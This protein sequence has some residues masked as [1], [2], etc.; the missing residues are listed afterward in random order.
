MATAKK[1]PVG[2]PQRSVRFDPKVLAALTKAAKED[3]RPLSALIQKIVEEWLLE[4]GF[5][6]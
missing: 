5:L 6:K 2:R 3:K 1:T 4:N